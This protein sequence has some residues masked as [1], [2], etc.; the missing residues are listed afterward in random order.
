MGVSFSFNL[1]QFT[2]SIPVAEGGS[3]IRFS[4]PFGPIMEN[5]GQGE[6]YDRICIAQCTGDVT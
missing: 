3:E 6:T 5:I 2:Q 1:Q 4:C